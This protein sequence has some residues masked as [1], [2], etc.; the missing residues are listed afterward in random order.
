MYVPFKKNPAQTNSPTVKTNKNFE[1]IYI[2]EN[3]FIENIGL[4]YF[5]KL[6]LKRENL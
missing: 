5:Q 2:Q 3:V 6:S 4:L 1:K